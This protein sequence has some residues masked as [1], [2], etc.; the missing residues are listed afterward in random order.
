MKNMKKLKVE[1]AVEELNRIRQSHIIANSLVWIHNTLFKKYCQSQNYYYTRDINDILRDVSSKAVV[2]YKDLIGFYCYEDEYPQK[3]QLLAEY[4]KFHTDIPRFFM[5]PIIQL[6]NKYYDKMRRQ[7]YYRI[8]LLVEQ[9]EKKN[10]NGSSQCIIGDKPSFVNSQQSHKDQ[11]SQA[12]NKGIRNTLILKDLSWLNKSSTQIQKKQMDIS[13]TLQEICKQLGKETMEQSSLLIST[14]KGDEIELN[15]FQAYLNQQIQKSQIDKVSQTQTKKLSQPNVVFSLLQKQNDDENKLRLGSQYSKQN[16]ELVQL[17]KISSDINIRNQVDSPQ[18]KQQINHARVDQNYEIKQSISPKY[19]TNVQPKLTTQ[20]QLKDFRLN[21]QSN[22]Q[23][24]RLQNQNQISSPI[25]CNNELQVLTTK[26]ASISKL[27]LKQI[28]KIIIDDNPTPQELK[29]K[30]GA[31]TQR[32][33]SDT[34]N[35]FFNRNS[36][37]LQSG[38]QNELQINMPKQNSAVSQLSQKQSQKNI[39]SSTIR[40]S[41]QPNIHFRFRSSQDKNI[42]VNENQ[43]NQ[44]LIQ[45]IHKKNKSEGK[46]LHSPQQDTH[47]QQLC[48]TDRRSQGE[49]QLKK[50]LAK[51]CQNSQKIGILKGVGSGIDIVKHSVSPNNF[52]IKQMVLTQ[53][54]KQQQRQD[55]FSSQLRKPD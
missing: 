15:K 32:P 34:K 2:R 20:I 25:K 6:L 8:A 39:D 13:C 52:I 9:E 47:Q 10:P 17:N 12:H 28:S 36:P 22:H 40:K 14:G 55:L 35:F 50:S 38:A 31:Q 7:E 1:V 18:K 37:T 42:N 51:S 54:Q 11:E 29:W 30:N 43:Q 26:Q 23:L 46:Q 21:I 27:N 3:F 19:I 33:N 16:T 5:E 24:I 45:I 44:Q 48:L 53:V 49:L 41:M 4:Y